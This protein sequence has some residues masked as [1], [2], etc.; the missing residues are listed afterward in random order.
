VLAV[1]VDHEPEAAISLRPDG[2]FTMVAASLLRTLR[3]WLAVA[4]A[5]VDRSRRVLNEA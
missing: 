1:A 5:D 2:D 4:T 3:D